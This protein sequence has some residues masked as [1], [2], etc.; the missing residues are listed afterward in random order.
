MSVLLFE[1]EQQ[2]RGAQIRTKVEEILRRDLAEHNALS[3][4]VAREGLDELSELSDFQPDDFV[5]ESGKVGARLILERNGNYP[6]HAHA[7]RLFRKEQW[8]GTVARDQ[9]NTV[10]GVTHLS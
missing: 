2:S 7:P 4:V 9:A 10:D 8:Q 6:L 5:H 1:P 3:N